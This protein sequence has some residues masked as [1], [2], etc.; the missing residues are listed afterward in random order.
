MNT[1]PMKNL[2]LL[3]CLAAVPAV[4][5]LRYENITDAE[6]AEIQRATA[7]VYTGATVYISGV[8]VGCNCHNGSG[9]TDSASVAVY[10]PGST[11]SLLLSKIDGHWQV[12]PY[13]KWQLEMNKL[14]RSFPGFGKTPEARA[15]LKA[16]RE[17]EKALKS[18]EPAC[19]TPEQHDAQQGA[20]A[21]RSGS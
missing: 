5:A 12:G 8:E 10:K 16:Y 3:A 11:S 15:R 19:S 14:R 9:C 13:E 4:A 2:A 18:L 7:S 17:K 1:S 20:P 6:V 21:N